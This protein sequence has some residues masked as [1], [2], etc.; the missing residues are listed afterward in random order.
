M[1]AITESWLT[2]GTGDAVIRAACPPGYTAMH[3][4][5]PS[6][7]GGVAFIFKNTIDVQRLDDIVNDTFESLNLLV[8]THRTSQPFQLLIV[9]RPPSTPVQHFMSE[10]S[11]IVEPIL[12]SA[13][14]VLI[15]GDF[16]LHVGV[17]PDGP[18]RKFLDLIESL[19]LVQLVHAPTRKARLIDLVLARASD[20]LVDD[21]VVSQR[22]SDHNAIQ[23]L[24]NVSRP[25]RPFTT[26]SFRPY[27]RIDIEQFAADLSSLPLIQQPADDLDDLVRQYDEG[28][29]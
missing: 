12:A 3:R 14:R 10:F 13:R 19:G 15:I 11:S 8:A 20:R 4:P 16:N 9:Y 25:Q 28:I 24:L 6:T 7:G 2:A 29:A 17:N 1:L 23:C 22:L 21:L 26:V 5:R 27:S 18:G